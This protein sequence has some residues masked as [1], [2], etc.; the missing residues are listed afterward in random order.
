MSFL[1]NALEGFRG[2][3]PRNQ[4]VAYLAATTGYGV[5]RKAVVMRNAALT[6]IDYDADFKRTERT[7][8]VLLVDKALLCVVGGLSAIYLWPMYAV[9]DAR[10][11]EVALRDADP[12]DYGQDGGV[13]G[14]RSILDYMFD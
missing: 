2:L 12:G 6:V 8:P 14:R 1:R 10:R 5:A 3:T 13:G 9:L 4:H 7:T 11:V